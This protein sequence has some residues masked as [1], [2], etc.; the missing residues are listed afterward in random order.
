MEIKRAEH[1]VESFTD[2]EIT[3]QTVYW[4][5]MTPDCHLERFRRWLFAFMSVHTS[6]EGNCT[7]FLAIRDHWEWAFDK[8]KLLPLLES[9]GAGMHNNRAQFITDF[10]IDYFRNSDEFMPGPGETWETCRNRL[11]RRVTGLGIA[12]VSYALEMSD[13]LNADVMCCDVHQLRLYDLGPGDVGSSGDRYDVFRS[14]EAHWVRVCRERGV[15]PYVGRN[16][17]W[18]RLQGQPDCRFWSH[19]LEP[20]VTRQ[21]E[22][23]INANPSIQPT[24][25][26]ADNPGPEVRGDVGV[27]EVL[28]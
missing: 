1:I 4:R 12:K 6:W 18:N 26:V 9:S 23:N 14:A 22:I 10:A 20:Q 16:I 28:P 24:P 3:E 8:K 13:P 15:A 19:V 7:G 21:F 17:M 2:A 11:V 25:G 27:S 5:K